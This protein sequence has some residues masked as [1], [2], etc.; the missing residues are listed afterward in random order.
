MEISAWTVLLQCVNF[1]IFAYVIVRFGMGPVMNQLDARRKAIQKEIDD[2]DTIKKDALQLQKDYELKMKEAQEASAEFIANAVTH[3]E[4]MKKDILGEANSSAARIKQRAEKEA[5][6][7]KETA[8]REINAQIGDLAVSI[9]GKL[10]Q[11]SLDSDTQQKMVVSFI[12]KVESGD[13]R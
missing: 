9:A 2:A 11:D 7:M 6:S 8:L 12:E 10:L 3:G 13:V 4:N 5:V 1:L